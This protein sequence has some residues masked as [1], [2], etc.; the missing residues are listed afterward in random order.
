LIAGKLLAGR[1][2]AGRVIVMLIADI[3]IAGFFAACEK[4]N[5]GDAIDPGTLGRWTTHG[6]TGGLGDNFIWTIYEDSEG[7]IWAGTGDAGARKYDGKGWR[8]YTTMNGMLSDNVYSISQDADGDMWFG[9]AGGLNLLI[10]GVVY[11]NEN[12]NGMHIT[13]L[14]YDSQNRLWIGTY[15]D[16]LFMFD[17]NAFYPAY[18]TDLEEYN[19]INSIT[20]DG[21]GLIWFATEAAAIYFYSTNFY[22]VDSTS[23]M[24][25]TD[26]TYILEDSWD[27]LWFCN[28]YG[29][30]L[31]RYDGK[32][33]EKI[34]LYHG[35]ELAGTFSMTEDLNNNLWFVTAAGGIMKYNGLEM[36]PV[37]LPETHRD[38]SFNC[39]LTDSKGN[40]WFGGFRH[41]ILVY[42][43]E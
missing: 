12:F 2:I 42:H 14:F 4:E 22:I 25:S 40:L 31:T 38:E 30:F 34:Y 28:F 27:Y 19:Y 33:F 17:G 11:Y 35:F 23:G 43:N 6:A 3:L 1:S 10:D 16:G 8:G 21:N 20:E 36:V 7:N 5:A 37:K 39:S 13:A 41:G 9:T 26:I 29:E 18:F 32:S 15:G 24:Y